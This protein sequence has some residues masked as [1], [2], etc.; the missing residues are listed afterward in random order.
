MPDK[1]H[2]EAALIYRNERKRWMALGWIS[3]G[4]NVTVT[5]D[6]LCL[7]VKLCDA[8]KYA[9]W[10]ARLTVWSF[11]ETSEDS[12]TCMISLEEGWPKEKVVVPWSAVYALTAED[13]HEVHM[14]MADKEIADANRALLESPAATS[15][16]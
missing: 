8:A 13:W 9:T 5:F 15:R 12:F 7:G 14:W 2:P 6:P 3:E 4:V 11:S 1:E 16:N 10:P